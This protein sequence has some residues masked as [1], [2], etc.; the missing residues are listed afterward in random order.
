MSQ[1]P[2]PAGI[3]GQDT[4]LFDLIG[5]SM[6]DRALLAAANKLNIIRYKRL[7]TKQR[8]FVDY[9]LCY[10]KEG[11]AAKVAGFVPMDCTDEEADRCGRSVLRIGVVREAIEAAFEYYNESRSIKLDRVLEEIKAVAF[12]NIAD[13]FVPDENGNPVL[14]MPDPDDPNSRH[15]LA[16]VSEITVSTAKIGGGKNAQEIVNTKFKMHSKLSALETLLKVA[17]VKGVAAPDKSEG[18]TNNIA[19][20]QINIMPVPKGVHFRD[21]DDEKTMLAAKEGL[22]QLPAPSPFASSWVTPQTIEG[23]AGPG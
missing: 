8:Q 4:R 2:V 19:V 17:N 18:Q 20:T 9:Y 3:F 5:H 7:S 22:K 6:P 1:V 15:L 12:A 16:A 13:F 23:T 11:M 14:R 10:F 21:A